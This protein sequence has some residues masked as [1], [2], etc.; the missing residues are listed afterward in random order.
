MSN[1]S[2]IR[3]LAEKGVIFQATDAS[4]YGIKSVPMPAE[5]VAAYSLDPVEYIAKYYGVTKNQYLSWHRFSYCVLCADIT[6]EGNSC[7]NIITGGNAI[8]SPDRWLAPQGGYCHVHENGL[9][10]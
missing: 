8:D 1:E 2:F 4:P 3:D 9:V 6:V 5:D 7:R 10:R